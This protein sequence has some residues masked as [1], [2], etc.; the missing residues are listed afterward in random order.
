[1]YA[2]YFGPIVAIIAAALTL[3]VATP[4]ARAAL[5]VN[6]EQKEVAPG[7]EERMVLLDVY[8]VDPDGVNE[9][10]QGFD[11]SVVGTGNTPSGVRFEVADR[12]VPL[13][14]PS[15]AHP[16]VFEGLLPRVLPGDYGTTHDRFNAHASR[17]AAPLVDVSPQR[18][19]LLALPVLVPADTPP[20]VYE[21][22]VD[23]DPPEPF[24]TRFDAGLFLP[25][26][27]GQTGRITITPEPASGALVA[28][29]ALLLLRRRRGSHPPQRCSPAS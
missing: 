26:S 17:E 22:H 6:I 24:R 21:F 27:V 25:Y 19:G 20:G 23:P 8:L 16:Y 12:S 13:P 2:L 29:A 7:A 28:P 18:S 14:P 1:M 4:A 10:L 15:T 11:L 5:I 3:I 9:G